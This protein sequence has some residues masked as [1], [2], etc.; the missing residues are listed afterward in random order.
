[1]KRNEAGQKTGATAVAPAGASRPQNKPP[2]LVIGGVLY[3][4][5]MILWDIL[6][7]GKDAVRRRL[8]H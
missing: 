1:M 4:T 6:Q 5:Y 7:E 8:S 2:C 3:P